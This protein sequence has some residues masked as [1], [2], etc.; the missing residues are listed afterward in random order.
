M[1]GEDCHPQ[2]TRLEHRAGLNQKEKAPLIAAIG[3]RTTQRTKQ[4]NRPEL[5]G[6]QQS[7][8]YTG[9]PEIER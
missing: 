3:H 6:R 1:S 4:E 2:H 9:G 5:T 8:S 7:Q